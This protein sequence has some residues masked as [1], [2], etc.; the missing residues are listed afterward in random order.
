MKLN[1]PLLFFSVSCLFWVQ[2]TNQNSAKEAS[3]S[4]LDS[5]K[6][7]EEMVPEFADDRTP[8]FLRGLF[9]TATAESHDV[10]QLIDGDPATY[11][12]SRPGTGP[13]EGIMIR[14]F[15]NAANFV[16]QLVIE[17][18]SGEGFASIEQFQ[19]Y[20][21]DRPFGF[22]EDS[23]SIRIDTIVQSIFI[24]IAQTSAMDRKD[25]DL[26]EYALT[27]SKFDKE[28]CVG[29]AEIQLLGYDG[30]AYRLIAPKTLKGQIF[31]SSNLNPIAAYHAGLLFDGRRESAWAEG[32]EGPG[33]AD[34]LLFR[35][36]NTTR[37]TG[38]EIWNGHQFSS[39][40]YFDV[41]RVKAFSFGRPGALLMQYE[42]EDR[43]D[44]QRRR[45]ASAL[46][47]QDFVLKIEDV[48]TGFSYS[49]LA[50]SELLFFEGDQ[51]FLIYSDLS[52]TFE[53]EYRS[54]CQ[55]T[56]LDSVLNRRIYNELKFESE[57]YREQSILLRSDATFVA[58]S[59]TYTTDSSEHFETKADGNW[60]ILEA[61]PESAR[62]ELTG[63]YFQF[64]SFERSFIPSR[65]E[66]Y[67]RIFKDEVEISVQ[68][69]QG[70]RAIG[71]FHL[72]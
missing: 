43:P 20:I 58:Y 44:G 1:R 59:K 12:K 53:Q 31:P 66:T 69:L 70:K 46:E 3:G 2:C 41:P 14:F 4:D 30:E 52:S 50:I 45:L 55:N 21:N 35:L 47:G 7:L 16:Q 25:A 38:L 36:E 65:T 11:W 10:R 8:V 49:D 62:I 32:S 72:N 39:D 13:D 18:T 40:H 27:I 29:I 34:S 17:R 60:Q 48:Y 37:L 68:T 67:E 56:I 22:L 26:D 6:H 15:E 24:K 64:E 42:L 63:R 9:A 61:N 33:I 51:P 5:L 23:D 19:I 71:L 57:G 28:L 54:R